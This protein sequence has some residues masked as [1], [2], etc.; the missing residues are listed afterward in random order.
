MSSMYETYHAAHD[1]IYALQNPA[2]SIPLSKLRNVHKEAFKTLAEIFR[3]VKPPEVTTR[4]PVRE[5]G[6]KKLQEVS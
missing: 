1:I 5:L 2:P 3:K 6:Q 4:V